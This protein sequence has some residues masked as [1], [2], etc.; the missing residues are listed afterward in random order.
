M[1]DDGDNDSLEAIHDGRTLWSQG[2]IEASLAERDRLLSIVDRAAGRLREISIEDL[3]AARMI[4]AMTAIGKN[5]HR[6]V[7]AAVTSLEI[8]IRILGE[9]GPEGVADG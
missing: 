4:L 9:A 6:A 1:P 7:S 5:Y 2:A 3:E 8:A